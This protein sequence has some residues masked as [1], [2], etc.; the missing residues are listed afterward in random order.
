MKQGTTDYNVICAHRLYW[1]QDTLKQITRGNTLGLS[2]AEDQNEYNTI[3]NR[4]HVWRK[5][6]HGKVEN[7]FIALL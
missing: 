2:Y 7:M 1:V 6:H 4:S 5:Q 3:K